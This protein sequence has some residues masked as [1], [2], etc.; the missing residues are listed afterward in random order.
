M[1]DIQTTSKLLKSIKK[2]K[3][4]F[5]GVNKVLNTIKINF[6]FNDYVLFDS[7]KDIKRYRC[8]NR[9]IKAAC[10]SILKIKDKFIIS[11]SAHS[12][13]CQHR[14]R[15]YDNITTKKMKKSE[16]KIKRLKVKKIQNEAFKLDPTKAYLSINSYLSFSRK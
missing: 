12:R 6:D 7:N 1:S 14:I 2:P 9:S 8:T 11:L 10:K 13:Y 4:S 5:I 15:F 3:K 16:K